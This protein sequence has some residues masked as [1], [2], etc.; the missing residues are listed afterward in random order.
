MPRQELSALLPLAKQT[1]VATMTNERSQ[2]RLTAPIV[3]R[4]TARSRSWA[5]I[6]ILA[7]DFGPAEQAL[8][9][10]GRPFEVTLAG[11]ESFCA[12][13]FTTAQIAAATNARTENARVREAEAYDA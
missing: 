8:G 6:H 1:M 10:P 9:K 11:V 12:T 4:L 7:G 5:W 3:A 2:L 13:Q